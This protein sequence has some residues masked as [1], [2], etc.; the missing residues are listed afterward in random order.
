MTDLNYIYSEIFISL[1]IMFLLLFGVFK[2]KSSTLIHNFAI[3]SLLITL[4][5][6]FNHPLKIEISLF[7]DDYIIDYLSSFMKI[8]TLISGIFVLIVSSSYLKFH[9]IFQIEYS[10]LILTSILGM[11]VMISSN[12]LIVFYIGLELQS[13]SLYVLASFN[14][15]QMKSSEAGLKYFV[16]SALSSGLLLYGCSLIYGFS[17]STNFVIISENVSNDS[18]GLI[19]GLVFIL[20]G[21]AFKISAVPFHMWAP[22]VYEGSPTSVTLFFAVV[23]KVAALTIFI[24]ILYLPFFNMIDQWQIIIIFLAI[25]SMIFG[26]VAAIGQ[27]NIKRLIAY[28]SIGHMGY[29]LAGLSV[30]TNAG[31]QSSI[32]YISIYFVMNLALFCC[33]FMMRRN[34]KYYEEI[35]DLSGLSKNHPIISLSML[36]ILFSLAGVPPMAGFFAK[37]YIFTAVIEKSMY[38]LAVIGLLATVVSAF[39]YL[40]IIKIIYFDKEKEKYDKD[41]SLGLKITLTLSTLIIFLYFIF[42]SKL[43]EIVS[44]IN[45]I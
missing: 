33:L 29:V 1:S 15:D 22:D 31:I 18:F 17:G 10:I 4:L 8:L 25:A 12:D 9:K 11:M 39:Y 30:G 3:L 38:Y 20:V 34:G 37:F 5:L 28:S 19:F 32:I 40:R 35:E 24:R 26:A 42:P 23:P 21:L 43:V 7:K 6:I 27:K 45:M 2:K 44:Q 36:I 13:L 16:L 41:Y 14:R